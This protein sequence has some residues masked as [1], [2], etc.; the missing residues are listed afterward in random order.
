M[1][2]TADEQELL[3]SV[4]AS[5]QDQNLYEDQVI[6]QATQQLAPQL[7][8]IGLP[9][10][11]SLA[12]SYN[13]R[14]PERYNPS[15]ETHIFSILNSTRRKLQDE[16]SLTES[17]QNHL[18]LKEQLLISFLSTVAGKT[19]DELPVRLEQERVVEQKR[20]AKLQQ[21]EQKN[22]DE[23]PTARD[24]DKHQSRVTMIQRR[25]MQAPQHQEE[26]LKETVERKEQLR[27]LRV[28]RQ[29]RR[30]MRRAEETISIAS[31]ST[32]EEEFDESADA[33]KEELP[34]DE[35]EQP[36]VDETNLK[37]GRDHIDD[38]TATASCPLCQT[39]VR[40]NDSSQIDSVLAQH[41]NTCQQKRPSRRSNNRNAANHTDLGPTK[42]VS[43]SSKPRG[44][45]R[46]RST[47]T[48]RK[49]HK[50]AKV[51]GPKLDATDDL[52]EI[53]YEDRV[54][55]W[56][57]NGLSRMKEMKERD[58]TEALPGAENCDGLYIPAWVN[59]RL[60]G[61]QRQ[62]LHW[63]WNLHQQQVG[64]LIGD[65]MGLVRDG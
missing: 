46:K 12:P 24:V 5:L 39:L 61:Y 8:G 26:E 53:N 6:R 41:M 57:E 54:D 37:L 48:K 36:I 28:E 3:A 45:Q 47:Q 27:L 65:E 29:R 10:L 22:D 51:M 20:A 23:E 52:E 40:A 49:P 64:G 55:D 44:K 13:A 15:D 7:T 30:N 1:S 59:D 38:S 31:S 60:F 56:I 18:Q 21:N 14:Y 62:G 58:E 19:P 9:P 63:M 2:N 42:T 32:S 4:N 17:Q 50:K 33:E 34:A 16:T 11:F 35:S 43:L 25:T